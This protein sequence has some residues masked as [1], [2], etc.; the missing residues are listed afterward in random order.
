AQR[1]S[2]VAVDQ[3]P[4][5][6]DLDVGVAGLHREAMADYRLAA[7]LTPGNADI[8]IALLWYLIDR[9]E[10]AA[11]R[12][13][14]ARLL[15]L[16]RDNPAYWGVFAAA[17]HVLDRPVEAVA[18]YSRQLKHSGQD[19][20]WLLNYADALERTGQAGMAWRVR[21][22]TWR[23]LRRGKTAMGKPGSPQM[24]A[25]ARL[26]L[27]NAPGD[28]ALALVREIVRQDRFPLPQETPLSN[29]LPLAGERTNVKRVKQAIRE[30]DARKGNFL[31]PA[32]SEL[33]L[34]W[35]VSNEQNSAAK[36]WLWQRYGRNLTRPL[37]G[38]VGMALA[39]NDTKK[40]ERLIAEQ[41]DGLPIYNRNDAA[42]ATGQLRYAQ[43]IASDGLTAGPND[44]EL[45][46]RLSEDA[47]PAASSIGFEFRTER[48]GP[49]KGISREMSFDLALTPTLRLTGR[50]SGARQASGDR[51]ALAGVPATDRFTEIGFK[52]AN[53]LGKTAGTFQ[54][55]SEFDDALGLRLSHAVA[56]DRRLHLD[57]GAERHTAATESAALRVAGMKNQLDATL[58]YTFSK[59]EYLRLQPRWA[60]YYTQGGSYLG[61]G[62]MLDWEVGHLIRTEYPDWK[63][64]LGGAH[65]RFDRDGA[66]DAASAALAPDGLTPAVS[67]FLPDDADSRQLCTGFGEA[68][69]YTYTRAVRPY[70]DLCASHNNVSGGG[71]SGLLG[72]AASVFGHDH[73]TVYL[74]QSR[75]GAGFSGLS[76]ELVFRYYYFLDRY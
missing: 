21:Q 35:A 3:I 40:L 73:A 52:W 38:E 5:Q 24:L 58:L 43:S 29:S 71:Y 50:L 47:L 25:A 41:A 42:R 33:I 49:V 46:L 74:S 63:I 51:D 2:L 8:Q 19:Y 64:R 4:Q 68:Y 37:W 14:L 75:A 65:Y 57:L 16:S 36:A 10:A 48:F 31:T 45:H 53:S 11:L 28:P 17:H 72:I 44:D 7:A 76:R 66:S 6:R 59:R 26:A 67:F 54:R 70:A 15:P 56:L 39:E 12:E 69:R 61:S 60:R 20:L 32:I 30:A 23:E 18:F 13:S 27:Q 55:R 1:R 22:H 34:G 62:R 9:H